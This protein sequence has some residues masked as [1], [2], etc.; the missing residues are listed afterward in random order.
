MAKTE[1]ILTQSVAGLGAE[2]DHVKVASGYA[3][4]FL[5]PQG[6]AI[7][8]TA[9][10]K[11]RLEVLRERRSH[12]ESRELSTMTELGQAL[13]KL[14]L[15][16][17]AKTGDD[18]RLFGSVTSGTIADE[19]KNQYEAT[20]DKRKIHLVHPI[21]NVGDYEI[22][23]H[24]HPKVETT[25]KVRIESTTP[26]T[27]PPQAPPAP[28]SREQQRA[29]QAGKPEGKRE[30]GKAAARKEEAGEKTERKSRPSKSAKA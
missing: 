4:N 27:P 3:R 13:G 23:L 2:S 9:V 5:L 6:L 1:V 21:K 16:I 18:G 30:P 24:L 15:V 17:H 11:R 20:V 29:R 10:N 19:L 22:E 28:E 8:L 14:T 7:P 12:R 26:L 25:L